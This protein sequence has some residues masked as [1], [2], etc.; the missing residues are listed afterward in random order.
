MDRFA[1]SLR[2]R[3]DADEVVDGWVG[4]VSDTM[5]P[6]SIGVWTR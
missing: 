3:A 1:G 6:T 5:E 2:D 4:V